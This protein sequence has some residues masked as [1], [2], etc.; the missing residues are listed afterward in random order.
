MPNDPTFLGTVQ[1]V[2]G[3]TVNVAL[4]DNIGV[5]LAFIKG[6]GY[7]IGQLGSFVR[8]PMGYV[9]IFGIVSQVGASAVPERF[10]EVEPHGFRWMTVQLIGEGSRR[11]DFNRGVSQYPTIGVEFTLLPNKTSFGYTGVLMSQILL[12]W[13][14]WQALNLFPP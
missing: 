2:K 8:I 5:G 4:N 3:F 1:D 9:D 6:H 12:E 13:G 14:I 7:R 11:G 10:V